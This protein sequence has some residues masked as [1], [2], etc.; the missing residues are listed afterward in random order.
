MNSAPRDRG[1]AALN[2]DGKLRKL[3]S[4]TP[5]E[6]QKQSLLAQCRDARSRLDEG[7]RLIVW[8]LDLLAIMKEF[9]IA[10]LLDHAELRYEVAAFKL[11]ADAYKRRPRP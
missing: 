2:D 9:H 4:S 3:P 7:T 10:R 5:T 8:A 6:P 11:A 1:A